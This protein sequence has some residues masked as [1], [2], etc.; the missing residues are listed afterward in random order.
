MLDESAL[1]QVMQDKAWERGL[2]TWLLAPHQKPVFEAIEKSESGVYFLRC[3]RRVGKSYMLLVRA[4]SRCITE[5]GCHVIYLGPEQKQVRKIVSEHFGKIFKTAPA[6]FKPRFV[7]LDSQWVFDFNGSRITLAGCDSGHAESLRGQEAHEVLF[8][9]VGFVADCVSITDNILTPMLQHTDGRIMFATT[10]AKTPGHESSELYKRCANLG[11]FSRLTFWDNS[12]FTDEKKR[13]MFRMAYEQRGMDSDT[14]K[15]DPSYLREWMAED[16]VDTNYAV[17]P[18]WSRFADGLTVDF[19]VPAHFDAYVGADLGYKD[20]TGFV[21]AYI[22]HARQKLCVQDTL[23]MKRQTTL[24]NVDAA[25]A[26]ETRLWGDRRPTSRVGDGGGQGKQ[27]LVDITVTHGYPIIP[28][29]KTSKDIMVMSLRRLVQEQRLWVH[30]RCVDLLDQ[31]R[32][33]VWNEPRT[34]FERTA[35]GHGDLLDALIYLV[36]NLDWAKNPVP[37]SSYNDSNQFRWRSD[38]DKPQSLA[39]AKIEQAI[40]FRKIIR[41]FGN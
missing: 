25:K 17:I 16:V 28:A 2:L 18:E 9:E 39:A 40:G 19:T 6:K 27:I 23:L 37:A 29:S 15:A 14:F 36:C 38:K 8:D 10:P 35:S 41:R 32:N 22:D 1:K 11:A 20:G 12:L 5:P 30:P 21:F 33:T 13:R 34:G 24:A 26:M 7:N 4:V 3:A 31:L